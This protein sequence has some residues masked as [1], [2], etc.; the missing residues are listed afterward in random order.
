MIRKVFA[1]ITGKSEQQLKNEALRTAAIKGRFRRARRLIA[2]GADIH[3]EDINKLRPLD[4]A[5]SHGHVNILRLLLEAGASPNPAPGCPHESALISAVTFEHFDAVK[6]LVEFRANLNL[7]DQQGFTALH[8]AVDKGLEE[9]AE[10]L[11]TAGADP[12]T[13]NFLGRTPLYAAVAGECRQAAIALVE[14]G[15][16]VDV[17]NSRGEDIPAFAK[18]K[19]LDDVVAAIDRTR[20]AAAEAKQ[21]GKEALD[22]AIK[23][24]PVLQK[25]LQIKKPFTLKKR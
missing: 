12:N 13:K 10:F 25:D 4:F 15:A 20:H 16:N 8:R 9:M 21:K 11:C 3:Y 24:A 23:K 14:A 7:Q 18:R 6:L 2:E 5:A 17:V 19:G 1:K 22:A